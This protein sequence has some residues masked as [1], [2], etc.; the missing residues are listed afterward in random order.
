MAAML[1]FEILITS[2]NLRCFIDPLINSVIK[3]LL[4]NKKN[5]IKRN[6]GN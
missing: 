6:K 4:R 3:E 1:D 5:K 2:I